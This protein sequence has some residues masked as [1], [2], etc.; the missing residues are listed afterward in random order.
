MYS[1][2]SELWWESLHR[3]KAERTEWNQCWNESPRGHR[4]HYRYCISTE[5]V[6]K[7]DSQGLERAWLP[8]SALNSPCFGAKPSSEELCIHLPTSS[9][10]LFL[11]V[12]SSFINKTN[13]KQEDSSYFPPS[14]A[15]PTCLSF[16]LISILESPLQLVFLLTESKAKRISLPAKAFFFLPVIKF[17][18]KNLN[19][20]KSLLPALYI[21][22]NFILL[23]SLL[24]QYYLL[25]I[26]NFALFVPCLPFGF[27]P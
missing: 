2:N 6:M 7:A 26:F 19:S 24:L 11:L 20:Y 5:S 16:C 1:T 9:W 17:P 12:V 8:L 18:S 23:S 15:S 14:T 4:Q 25:S 27:D 21:C 10:T 13:H 3:E 22:R